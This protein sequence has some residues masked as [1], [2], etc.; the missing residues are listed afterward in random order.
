MRAASVVLAMMVALLVVMSVGIWCVASCCVV[1][2]SSERD[3]IGDALRKHVSC[4]VVVSSRTS[5]AHRFGAP[6]GVASSIG[7][8]SN[9]S[10]YVAHR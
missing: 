2:V 3:N 4:M 5:V 7:L 9:R 1:V 8:A 6:S 10:S